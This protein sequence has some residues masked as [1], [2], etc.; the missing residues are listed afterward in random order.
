MKFFHLSDLHLGK[1]VNGYSMIED[2]K[3]ILKAILNS[4][5]EYKPDAVIIAGDVYDKSIP[6][7]EAVELFDDYLVSLSQREVQVFIISGNHDS[8]ERLAFGNKLIDRT[9]IHIS[10]VYNGE[11]VSYEMEDEYGKVRFYL[12]PFIR[13]SNVR[14]FFPE[15]ELTTYTDAVRIA[16]SAVKP[17]TSLRNVMIAHQFIT[18]ASVSESEEI[19]V[20]TVENVDASVFEEY[21]YVALGHIHGPQRAGG[22]MIRYCGTPLKYSTS[23]ASQKKSITCVELREKGN[24]NI[25]TIPLIPLRDLAVL[26]GRYD[27]LMAKSF[28][29]NTT[30]CNDYVHITLTDEDDIPEVISKLRVVY[31]NLLNVEY[32][33]RRTRHDSVITGA[34]QTERKTPAELFSD[35]FREQNGYDMSEKQTGIVNALIEEI[36]GDEI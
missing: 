3:Y 21:D 31:K 32:D 7:T 36:W 8:P 23:E 25:T 20:G 26:R 9:G 19:S 6:S 16:L 28:Y 5:D 1:K 35:F 10:P 22:D 30:Y 13:P 14:R 34:E 18:G 27:E 17:D 11:L 33:N 24:V 29:E 2:Q 4:I 12:L 15:E